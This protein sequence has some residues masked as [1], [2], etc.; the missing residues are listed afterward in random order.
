MSKIKNQ[1][2]K[3]HWLMTLTA[4]VGLSG[5]IGILP[6]AAHAA[7]NG[8][9]ITI[10]D[11]QFLWTCGFSPYNSSSNFLSVGPVY[12][13]LSFVNTMQNAKVTP[14]LA[15]SYAWSDNNTVLTFT[16]RKGVKWSD[17]VDFT[18]ADVV[19]T[20]NMLKKYPAL[21]V[22]SI[23]SALTSVKQEGG[24][25]VVFTF[26][27]PSVPYFYY[28]ADQVGIV[29]Q[30][31]WSKVANPVTYQDA[32]PIGTGAFIVK[33]CTPQNIS[34]VRNDHYWQ[35]GLPKIAGIEYPAFTTNPPANEILSTGQ[36]QWGSQFIPNI[37]AQYLSK[38]KDNH[39]WFPPVLNV[40]IF[41]NQA[42]PLLKDIA[43]RKAMV[44][45]LDKERISKIGEYGYEPAANQAGIV[46]PTFESWLDK[47]QLAAANYS[48]DPQKAIAILEAAGYKRGSDG[49]FVSPDG[50]ELAFTIINQSA[51]TDWVAS[52]Q[53]ISQLYKA[54][55]IKL[56]VS[57]L[58]GTDYSAK[59]YNGDYDLAYASEAGGPSPYYEFRQWLF[60]PGSAPIG[61]AATTDWERYS[62]PS[63]D[64][65][66]NAYAASTDEATQH[67]IMNKLQKIM[68][69]D[70]PLIPVVAQV[71]WDEYS[72]KQFT[73][74]PTPSDPYAQPYAG[75]AIPDWGV[76]M[77][78]VHEK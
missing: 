28:I 48:Y 21:D 72:T 13:T 70:V 18:P 30:H 29:S 27:A 78:H 75:Y 14:W 63:T 73:G 68:L 76:D 45:A 6:K 16:I 74:W 2:S 19:F 24:D 9:V 32:N 43:V 59:L 66:I 47:D 12:E 37:K 61:Q 5:A 51:Y 77:L 42:N 10:S 62:N 23:W 65:L 69:D 20:F 58:A 60:S 71:D 35:P 40:A 8:G 49:Y 11:A 54:V 50:K 7:D 33:H 34:Y 25:K 38:D 36:A 44:Y 55:G 52:L 22:N 17:G 3:R 41:I 26:N 56:T 53:V 1:N 57:N 46:T 67:E 64:A 4:A 39:Y 15:T 31:V